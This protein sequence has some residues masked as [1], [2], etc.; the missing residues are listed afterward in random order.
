MANDEILK[1]WAY[2]QCS[3]YRV[4]T[5]EYLEKTGYDM[6]KNIANN[7]GILQNHISTVLSELKKAGLVECINP[8]ARKGRL[9]RLTDTGVEVANLDL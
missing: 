4:K 2:V 9:Y 7:V 1:K 8:E 6:P 3:T 5:L